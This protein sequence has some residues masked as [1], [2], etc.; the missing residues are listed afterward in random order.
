MYLVTIWNDSACLPQTVERGRESLSERIAVCQLLSFLVSLPDSHITYM[1]QQ[2]I[3]HKLHMYNGIY[4][5]PLEVQIFDYQW[6][7]VWSI[8]IQ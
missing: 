6:K 5:V 7:T 1:I 4:Y 8:S 3:K 2:Q